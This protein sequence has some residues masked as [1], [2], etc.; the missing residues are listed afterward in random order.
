MAEEKIKWDEPTEKVKWD[1]PTGQ[2]D[3]SDKL[4]KAFRETPAPKG[5]AAP[6]IGGAIGELTKGAGALTEL[7]A[8]ETGKKITKV[9]EAILEPLAA[10]KPIPT[11]I[12]RAASYL[13]PFKGVQKGVEAFR[14]AR[15]IAAPTKFAPRTAE[16]AGTGA[17]VAGATTPGEIQE[18]APSA[19]LGAAL[20]VGA[21]ALPFAADATGRFFR[22]LKRPEP[23]ADVKGLKDIGKKIKDEL[24][25]LVNKAYES[26][27]SEA[28]INYGEALKAARGKQSTQAFAES[29]Q[30]RALLQSLENDKY[31]VSGGK[32]FL[33]GEDEVKAIDSLIGAIKGVTKGGEKVPVG[34]GLVSAKITKELPKTKLEKDITA[35][36]EELRFLRD[37]ANTSG[38][39]AE[40]YAALQKQ[41]RDNLIQ[42]LEQSLYQWS[43]EYRLADEAYKAASQKLN[44]FQTETMSKALRGEK[45]DFRQLAASDE[46]IAPL[47]F[48]NADTVRQLKE[49]TGDPARINKMAKEYVAT[50][51]E[52]K[53]P[54]QI[55]TFVTDPKNQ[56]WLQE[57]GIKQEVDN[58]ARKATTAESR[59]KIL[60]RLGTGAAILSVIGG[61]GSVA[62]KPPL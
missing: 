10:E 33:K 36:I 34:K 18:R 42:R 20:G 59:Q 23:I 40:K 47:F 11:T 55:R 32:K 13:V 48:K 38:A 17:L 45:F 5:A 9:G 51:L 54:E 21:E 50:M 57:S 15:G 2:Q 37:K 43:D 25:S 3:W 46:E 7:F 24:G 56:G 16:A 31:V 61:G 12:G 29:P 14:S 44:A 8:P 22:S 58:F 52:N 30:G 41:Y 27:K 62:V 1:E 49:V 35:V 4:A 60:K 6:M 26:R 28:S 53:T 39:P 19:A